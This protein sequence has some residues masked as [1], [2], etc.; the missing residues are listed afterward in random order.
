MQKQAN[1]F[2]KQDRGWQKDS[3]NRLEIPINRFVLALK[4]KMLKLMQ[5]ARAAKN[6]LVAATAAVEALG[7][8][9]P[10]ASTSEE[11]KAA[12]VAAEAEMRAAQRAVAELQ[13]RETSTSAPQASWQGGGAT[14][15]GA[16]A[17]AGASVGAGGEQHARPESGE[18]CGG[19]VRDWGWGGVETWGRC[20]NRWVALLARGLE[21]QAASK[22][23][24]AEQACNSHV[25]AM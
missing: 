25:T 9:S 5:A 19:W 20:D 21:A 15:G 12:A 11:A 2:L 22:E 23:D 17:T 6:A 3:R 10:G 13:V 24:T 7:P 8:P 14:V 4:N 16:A 1:Y 18:S